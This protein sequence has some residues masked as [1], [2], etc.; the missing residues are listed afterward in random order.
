MQDMQSRV[1]V[2]LSAPPP[3][4]AADTDDRDALDAALGPRQPYGVCY[5]SA[6][7]RLCD[8]PCRRSAAVA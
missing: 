3:P 4:P 7:H 8:L 6:R 2:V 1:V 5:D